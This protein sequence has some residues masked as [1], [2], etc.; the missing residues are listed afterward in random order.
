MVVAATDDRV[1]RHATSGGAM[2]SK[3]VSLGKAKGR[4]GGRRLPVE[5]V[6]PEW[7]LRVLEYRVAEA[8]GGG[9][10]N[11]ERVDLNNVIEWYLVAP[12]TIGEVPIIEQAL[13]GTAAA[14]S[15]WLSNSTYGPF[16]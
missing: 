11:N 3:V 9:V 6:L 4:H 1:S 2:T 15:E 8:N 13:P 10:A 14:L 7:L 5:V 12:I 16:P